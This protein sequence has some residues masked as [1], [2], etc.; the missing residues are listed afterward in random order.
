ME[1]RLNQK[2]DDFAKMENEYKEF[3]RQE[4][5]KKREKL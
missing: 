5:T 2:V 4:E 1:I 3:K